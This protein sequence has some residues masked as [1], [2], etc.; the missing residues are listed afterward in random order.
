[1]Y[2]CLVALLGFA[3]F[4]EGQA[5]IGGEVEVDSESAVRYLLSCRKPN[6]AFGPIDQEHSDL[7]WN[8]PAVHALTLLDIDIPR[9]EDCLK[10]GQWAAFREKDAHRTNLHWDLYQKTHLNLL[11]APRLEGQRIEVFPGQRKDGRIIKL[12]KSWELQ[13]KDRKALYYGPYGVGVFYDI[14]TLWYM[15]DVL[16]SLGGTISNPGFAKDY[17]CRR[18]AGNGGFGGCTCNGP[19]RPG[20][21]QLFRMYPR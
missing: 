13:Y 6:G 14:P 21:A 1:M 11:L 16:A 5:V 4:V 17:I 7:A 9:A 3:V 8:Y 20:W 10:N 18:Q 15:V 2:R 12:A 19:P